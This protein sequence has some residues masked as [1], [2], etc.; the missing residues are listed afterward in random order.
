MKTYLVGILYHEPE[1]WALYQKGIIE[2]YESST[3][4][5][6]TAGTESEALAWGEHVAEKLLQ[7]VNHDNSLNWKNLGYQCWIEADPENSH[8]RHCLSFFQTIN[9]GQLPKIEGMGTEAYELWAQKN[10]AT[11]A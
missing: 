3:G 2:D 1:P 4:L 10:G 11:H 6:I 7:K 9:A 8:W 5:F